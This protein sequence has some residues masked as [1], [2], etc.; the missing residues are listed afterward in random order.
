VALLAVMAALI[1]GSHHPGCRSEQC[2]RRVARAQHE[3]T[4]QAWARV[5]R[6]YNAWLD[7][8]AWCES[9]GRYSINTH[10]GYFG[11]LQFS[12]PSWWAVGGHGYPHEA[13]R[14]EQRY[15]AVR[16]LRLQGAGAWPV[17]GR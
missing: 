16:L 4:R 10:N 1:G 12:L 13:E 14:L 3:L 2:E 17:C 11:G 9:R 7:R 8:V 5:V 6:P 15:R